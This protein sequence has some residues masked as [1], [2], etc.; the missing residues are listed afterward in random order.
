MG[1]MVLETNISTILR[2]VREMDKLEQT[3]AD[4]NTSVVIGSPNLGKR[5]V[6]HDNESCG[7]EG[8]SNATIHLYGDNTVIHS[9]KN[10]GI[11]AQVS[12]K[13][14][15]HLP[16]HHNTIYNNGTRSLRQTNY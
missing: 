7:V 5:C 4:S 15:I 13:V 16:S 2:G 6:F 8:M 12:A 3:N 9:N 14:L 11:S 1:G 10:K